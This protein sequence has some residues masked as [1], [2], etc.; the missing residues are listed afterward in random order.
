M[1]PRPHGFG[2]SGQPTLSIRPARASPGHSRTRNAAPLMLGSMPLSRVPQVIEGPARRTGLRVEDEFVQEA[3]HDA[4]T[5]DALPLLAF[6][7]RELLD[8][9]KVGSLTLQAY[10]ALG[11]EAAGL[12]PLENAVRK[13]ADT[14]LAEAKATDEEQTALR[15]AFVPALMRVNE[16]GE[17]ARRP[18]RMDALAPTARPLLERL[19][20]ARLLIIRQDGDARVVEVAHEALLRK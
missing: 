20:K 5:E 19:A 4:E 13:A 16:Q 6:T 3:A 11:D 1:A 17:Y 15:E 9:S 14:V 2:L 12:T 18:A 8:R 10:R 7:L